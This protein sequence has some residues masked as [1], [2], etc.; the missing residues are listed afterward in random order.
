MERDTPATA[1][2]AASITYLAVAPLLPFA[3]SSHDGSR[4]LQVGLLAVVTSLALFSPAVPEWTKH[5]S[6]LGC[7]A[8]SLTLALG[9]LLTAAQFGAAA[10]EVALL[11]GLAVVARQAYRAA[12]SAAVGWVYDALLAASCAY[13]T[14]TLGIYA[15]ALAEGAPLNAR[16]LHLG[17]DN[18]RFFNHAQTLAVPVLLGW[19]VAA[20][21][22][23]RRRVALGV[24]SL[25]FAWLFM[26][27]ARASLLALAVA[28]VWCACVG[29]TALWRRLALSALL[30]AGLHLSLFVAL[31]RLLNR[32]WAGQ[33]ASV[34]ELGSSHSRDLLLSA[35]LEQ[36]QAHP[37]LGAGPMHFAALAHPKG[38]HP[39]NLYLQW[40]A[41]FGLPSLLLL[42]AL[43]L[44][45][46]WRASTTLRQ[47]RS[48]QHGMTAALGAAIVAALV[49]AGFSGNFVMPVSQVWIALVYGLL[50]AE[51]PHT[52]ALSQR[53]RASLL[54][55]LPLMTVQLWLAAVT[56][57]QWQYDPPRIS[58]LSPVTTADQ[59]PRPRFWQQGWL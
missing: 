40:A 12:R 33:F 23:K 25:H 9:S 27:L 48:T 55:M 14:L 56:W 18:P 42:L 30:G 43:L 17:F 44:L 47:T 53:R 11:L 49:D 7:G 1:A 32:N 38:A 10:Q 59:K 35:A 21:G 36:I 57:Q 5:R 19:S 51:L 13:F 54:P 45:P 8:A 46:L 37:W 29:A 31:P 52:T 15:A 41:E 34:Q 50:W 3:V 6:L 22:Q 26:D 58:D 28:A 39:H 4:L 20:P 24:A 2:L 16:M